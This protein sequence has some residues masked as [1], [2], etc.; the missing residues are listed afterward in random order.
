M[1]NIHLV[2]QSPHVDMNKEGRAWH[3]SCDLRFVN[4]ANSQNL[5]T[6]TIHQGSYQAPLKLIRASSRADGR[7]ELPILHTAGGLV[8]GD[9][10]TMKVLADEGSRSLLTNVAA[11]KVYGSI[12]RSKIYPNGQWARQKCHFEIKEDSDCEWMPQEVIIFA[13][14]LFEQEMYVEL[15]ASSSF[16]SAE[17]VR[18]GRT[19]S[20]ETLGL[21]C[22]RSSMEICRI[23]PEGKSWE[24]VDRLELSGEALSSEHGMANQPVMGSLVWAA[25]KS[26]SQNA[27][28]NLLISC[29]AKRAGLEG[30]MSCSSISQGISAR[31]RGSSTQAA[32]FWFFRIWA[33]VRKLRGL[34]KP[35][36]LRVWPMQE[37]P[38]S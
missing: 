37:Y 19:T 8:G 10:L 2:P 30:L 20:N 31:Y 16:L 18:L 38:F 7:C 14:G 33:Q 27:I 24:F 4:R 6:Y 32:R 35:E 36:A 22:W 28:D 21:G 5:N 12:G 1:L 11:Q 9:H 3:G 26:V 23:L 17:V 15:C 25:P 13:N 34:S 29:R